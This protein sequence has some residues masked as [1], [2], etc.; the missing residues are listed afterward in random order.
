MANTKE[1]I[2]HPTLIIM[3]VYYLH[4][5]FKIKSYYLNPGILLL[6]IVSISCVKEKNQPDDPPDDKTT[7]EVIVE[8]YGSPTPWEVYVVT[9]PFIEILEVSAFGKVQFDSINEGIYEVY[10]YKK[11]YGCNVMELDVKQGKNSLNIS[12]IE[13][14]SIFPS[15]HIVSPEWGDGYAIGENIDFYA[16]IDDPYTPLEQLTVN[17]YSNR[18]GFLGTSL[19]DPNGDVVFST[20]D[21]TESKHSIR[22]EVINKVN[23]SAGDTVLINTKSPREITLSYEQDADFNVTL[24][25]DDKKADVHFYEVYR[26]PAGNN[27]YKDEVLLATLDNQTKTY[28]D[29]LIP[30]CDSARYYVMAYT[31]DN[32]SRKS[33]T[34]NAPGLPYFLGGIDQA[35]F[36]NETGM[37]YWLNDNKVSVIDYE[38]NTVVQ[39]HFVAD[40]LGD[41]H[42]EDNGFGPEFYAPSE[43]GNLY[44]Y[45]LSNFELQETL[46][47]GYPV[48]SI[49]SNGDG[50]LFISIFPL[51]TGTKPFRVYS[52]DELDL[53]D[54]GGDF[55][56]GRLR[57]LPGG[58]EIIEIIGWIIPKDMNYYKVDENGIIIQEED[59][60][61]HG[62]YPLSPSIFKISPAQEYLI[63]HWDGVLYNANHTMVYIG[64]IS[65]VNT[66]SFTDF[67]FNQSG[68]KIFASVTQEKQ[69]NVYDYPTLNQIGQLST[70]GYPRYLFRSGSDIL[71]I[72]R[73]SEYANA[74]GL[75]VFEF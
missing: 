26:W 67:E 23:I 63:T 4:R 3:M 72:C 43:D 5:F 34:V 33:N 58:N 15:A 24:N 52:R 73:I 47:I 42:I 17:W 22:V 7:L 30:Y 14:I 53:K 11:N 74:F 62:T 44:I 28:T 35:L 9:H 27:S 40:D 29:S 32:Y 1:R 36:Y 20:H 8:N 65:N 2:I 6:L 39:E 21:L 19:P 71:A 75:E 70:Q 16:V 12:L 60:P 68:T 51:S 25:W 41:I 54:T 18:D 49:S 69:I 38:T 59:D 55:N 57:V 61:Y 56:D 45:D 46:Q 37:F 13:G 50:L 10:A 31:I 64:Q 66:L 48:R